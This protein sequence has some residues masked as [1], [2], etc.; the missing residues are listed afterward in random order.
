MAWV[1]LD[2]Q[3][4]EN[5]RVARLSPNAF[6]LYVIALCYA[7]RNLTDG[8]LDK[9]AIG[10]SCAIMNAARPRNYV[11][12]LVRS[13]LWKDLG[14]GSYQIVNYLDYN[15]AAE[16]VK[17]RKEE[18]RKAGRAGAAARWSD[19]KSYGSSHSSSYTDPHMPPTPTPTQKEK[20]FKS[21]PDGSESIQLPGAFAS[22]RG[23]FPVPDMLKDMPA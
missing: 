18:R 5:D 19:G 23:S 1:R 10:V 6:R 11:L 12:E 2:D 20:A 9:R 16:V 15:P 14:E 22:S 8:R 3:F 21:V 7:S 4:P 13:E 17:A